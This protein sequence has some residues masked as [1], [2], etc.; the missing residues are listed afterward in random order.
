V[1][2]SD[3]GFTEREQYAGIFHF[4]F[5]FGRW[6]GEP[7]ETISTVIVSKRRL[8]HSP[9][10]LAIE[11][12]LCCPISPLSPSLGLDFK[13]EHY[14]DV[15]ETSRIRIQQFRMIRI[16]IRP[17]PLKNLSLTLTTR[18]KPATC[19]THLEYFCMGVPSTIKLMGL[20]S[21]IHQLYPGYT[22]PEV[23]TKKSSKITYSG[24]ILSF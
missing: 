7:P 16:R 21:E 19:K 2:P 11:S 4:R 15:C 18:E 12:Y 10:K 22:V 1:V 5:W 24:V 13:K 20:F 3:Q 17:E 23:E 9:A 8:A 14:H 6:I